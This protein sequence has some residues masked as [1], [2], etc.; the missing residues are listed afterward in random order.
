MPSP[1]LLQK[2]AKILD[3]GKKV[4]ILV[5]KFAE[6]CRG[7]Q[8]YAR[9]IGLTLF[10]NQV[11]ETLKGCIHIQIKNIQANRIIIIITNTKD[12]NEKKSIENK[13]KRANQY[14]LVTSLE[15]KKIFIV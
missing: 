6:A 13:E 11:H 5:A 12:H 2:A 7:S 9:R 8:P 4:V 10:R 14:E 1:T 15:I 3:E